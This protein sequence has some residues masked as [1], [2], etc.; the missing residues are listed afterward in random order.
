MDLKGV[1]AQGRVPGQ[2]PETWPDLCLG[3]PE[4]WNTARDRGLGTGPGVKDTEETWN[5]DAAQTPNCLFTVGE[6]ARKQNSS[7][8]FNC[9]ESH[10]QILYVEQ[11]HLHVVKHTPATVGISWAKAFTAGCVLTTGLHWYPGQL[12]R[13]HKAQCYSWYIIYNQRWTCSC[14]FSNW[15]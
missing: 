15:L 3:A 7:L 1:L 13:Q 8:F 11:Q 12:R 14:S 4:Y 10:G 5:P 6:A 9:L 2:Q